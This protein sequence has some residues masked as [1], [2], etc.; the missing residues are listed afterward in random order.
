MEKLYNFEQA[1]NEIEQISIESKY[2]EEHISLAHIGTIETF[3]WERNKIQQFTNPAS[4]RIVTQ[5][6]TDEDLE[7]AVFTIRGMIHVKELPPLKTKPRISAHKYKFLRQ[8]ITLVGLGTPTF[9]KAL[10]AIDHI[11]SQFDRH[12]QEGTLETQTATIRG[13]GVSDE[14]SIWNRYLTPSREAK[15]MQ[16]IPF[17]PGV[18]PT[19]ILRDM[20]QENCN[21]TYVHTE[22]NQ[23]HYFA[24][25]R[26]AQGNSKYE[27]R[28]PHT[29]RI[30]DIVEAQVS[31]VVIPV[32]GGRRKMLSVLRSLALIKGN[33]KKTEKEI[34]PS[35]A[36][37]P[38][39]T[40][41]KRRS[42]Y[43]NETS[44]HAEQ[45]KRRTEDMCIDSK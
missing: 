16:A 45:K 37:M 23:V 2:D 28:E 27:R 34:Y 17:L 39:A 35:E 22:D 44:K 3:F 40:S 26:D 41:I 29:F 24:A 14:F 15:G 42:G 21:Y 18:D 19:G 33:F 9:T 13:D 5:G 38:K 25:L 11:H 20:A 8:G 31:F 12:L 1:R 32:K 7:E 43:T 36:P 6:E 30:G 4:W 10:E